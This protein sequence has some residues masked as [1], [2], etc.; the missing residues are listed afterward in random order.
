MRRR[1]PLTHARFGGE[2]RTDWQLWFSAVDRAD[3]A[4]TIQDEQP[5]EARIAYLRDYG[6]IK[7]N[8]ASSFRGTDY[9]I[10]DMGFEIFPMFSERPFG[11]VTTTTTPRGCFATT[12]LTSTRFIRLTPTALTADGMGTS[13][14]TIP[15]A[16][17]GKLAD[18]SEF[19]E[20][21]GGE[22][23]GRIQRGIATTTGCLRRNT[24][25]TLSLVL[26]LHGF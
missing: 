1:E 12:V 11:S 24:T 21:R 25:S 3:E 4:G 10:N 13:A 18:G 16:I 9:N 2:S 23:T 26:G 17:A 6:P 8:I 15:F 7:A 5:V 22:T 14:P 20:I 19:G